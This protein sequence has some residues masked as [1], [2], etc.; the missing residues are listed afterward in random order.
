LASFLLQP[1]TAFCVWVIAI[2]AWHV[3]AAY[4]AAIA[5]PAL[6]AAEHATFVLAGLLVWTQIVDPTRHGRAAPGRRALFAAAVLIAGAALS[7]VLLVAGPLYPHYEEVLDRPW[8][9]T[10]A[11]D[12][13]RAALLMMGE[14]IAT[15][16]TAALL[17]LWSHA[18]KV[19]RELGA[20]Y[21]AGSDETT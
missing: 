3:P 19:E 9:W 11:E 13:R 18:E 10:A 21:P 2:A 5:Q 15:L 14:Q 4:D 12:Q 8:G 1:A 16:G 6:H 17:L 20:A 7:E